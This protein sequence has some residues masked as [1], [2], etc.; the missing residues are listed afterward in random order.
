MFGIGGNHQSGYNYS[1][2]EIPMPQYSESTVNESSVHKKTLGISTQVL[3][4][5]KCDIKGQINLTSYVYT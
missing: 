2:Y 4:D 1:S 5:G 3:T